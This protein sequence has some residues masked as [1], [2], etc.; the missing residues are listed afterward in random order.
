MASGFG[1]AIHA[2]DGG[3]G[4]AGR[5][6]TSD[7]RPMNCAGLFSSTLRALCEALLKPGQAPSKIQL[8]GELY[9]PC[10]IERGANRPSRSPV[11]SGR[12][13]GKGRMIGEIEELGPELKGLG[14]GELESLK[15]GKIHLL[16]A[17]SPQDVPTARSISEV[18]GRKGK[19]VLCIG[20]QCR[21]GRVVRGEKPAGHALRYNRRGDHIGSL[22]TMT[23]IR[24]I[25]NCRAKGQ[26]CLQRQDARD[27]PSTQDLVGPARKSAQEMPP[28][29]KG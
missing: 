15:Q 3:R 4:L 12:G 24:A 5:A 27:L 10:R 6:P 19:P 14:F 28:M 16:Q 1:V 13:R 17:V 18:Q 8:Q 7:R 25:S 2:S 9:L 22:A 23:R 21:T 26:A 11:N 20:L 29:S